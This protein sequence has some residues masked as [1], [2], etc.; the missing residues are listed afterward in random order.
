MSKYCIA[1]FDGQVTLYEVL[2]ELGDVVV[3]SKSGQE[4]TLPKDWIQ[5][6][7]IVSFYDLS[8]T[9]VPHFQSVSTSKVSSK[10]IF[11]DS[12]KS[13]SKAS[14]QRIDSRPSVSHDNVNSPKHYTASNLECIDVMK[15]VFGLDTVKDFCI[16]NAWKYLWR[17]RIKN[18]KEDIEKCIW[19][20]NRYLSL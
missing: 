12:S 2:K 14:K 5:V 19:Y 15:E 7:D 9:Q 17:H 4:Y 20:L 3:I 6:I 10:E 18:G 8:C 13:S 1:D 16:C 11:K